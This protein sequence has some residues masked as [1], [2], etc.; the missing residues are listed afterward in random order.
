M[1]ARY[2][3]ES[4]LITHLCLVLSSAKKRSLPVLLYSRACL[5]PPACYGKQMLSRLYYF[6]KHSYPLPCY[7]LWS[8]RLAALTSRSPPLLVSA[9]LT[10]ASHP[11]MPP[12]PIL[13]ASDQRRTSQTGS[14]WLR[15]FK[16][17]VICHETG[18]GCRNGQTT[19]ILHN[20]LLSRLRINSTFVSSLLNK[21]FSAIL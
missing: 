7:F 12:P 21:G 17:Q 11:P 19:E 6:S 2:Y 13:S 9:T 3:C 10:P 14:W 4:F 1:S 18:R 16:I 5:K 20:S 15:M 8:A